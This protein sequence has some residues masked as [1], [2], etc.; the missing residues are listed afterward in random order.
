MTTEETKTNSYQQ[1]RVPKRRAELS[2]DVKNAVEDIL[3]GTSVDSHTEWLQRE[4][5]RLMKR[6]ANKKRESKFQNKD[7][8]ENGTLG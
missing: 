8:N 1:R 3:H 5:I 6:E 7:V 2:D 4:Y